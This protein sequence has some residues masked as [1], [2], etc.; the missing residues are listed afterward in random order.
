MRNMSLS[1]NDGFV[2]LLQHTQQTNNI[3][4]RGQTHSHLCTRPVL[5]HEWAILGDT[6]VPC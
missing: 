6:N 4:Y 1:N 2:Y 5:V 3:D